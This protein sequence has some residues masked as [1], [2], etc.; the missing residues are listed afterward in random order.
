[1][2]VSVSIELIWRI[3]A[4][5]AIAGEYMEI[6]PEHFLAAV[7]KF[8]ELPVAALEQLNSEA[9]HVKELAE[10]MRGI[11]E[12]LKQRA[13]DSTELRYKIRARLG[14]GGAPYSGGQIHRAQSSREIFEQAQKLAAEAE[15][16]VFMAIHVLLALLCD[17]TPL[18][19]E[20]LGHSS[21]ERNDTTDEMSVLKIHGRDL[22]AAVNDGD[23]ARPTG[24]EAECKGLMAILDQV[25]PKSVLLLTDMKDWAESVVLAFA[26]GIRDG[27]FRGRVKRLVDLTG[28]GPRLKDGTEAME[29]MIRAFE[30]ATSKEGIM[31]FVPPILQNPSDGTSHYWADRLKSAVAQRKIRCICRVSEDAYEKWISPDRE[32]R[33]IAHVMRIH[34]P[35]TGDV[36]S[37]L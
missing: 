36:P 1:M 19:S 29:S 12:A 2:R 23:A 11:D 28:L 20:L 3:A 33:R 13:L 35:D 5:E 24:R 9:A 37:E 21:L 8:S 17:P 22:V 14:K 34:P 26:G 10:E 32:W 15:S 30:E 4:R 18:I 25:E 27:T 16:S 31:L 6:L 7:F